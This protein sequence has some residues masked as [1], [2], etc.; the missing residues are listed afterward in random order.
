MSKKRLL[1]VGESSYLATGFS[2]YYNEV[3][4]RLHNMGEFEIAELGSYGHD[5]DPRNDLI[6]WKFYPAMPAP[7]DQ[8]GNAEYNSDVYNQFGKWRF[9]KVCLDFNPDIVIDIRDPWMYSWILRS[10]YRKHFNLFH[11]ACCDGI[12]QKPIWIEEYKQCDK[13]FTYSEWAKDI[14][15]KDGCNVADVMSPCADIDVFAPVVDKKAHKQS[16]GIDPE[17]YIIGT[18]MRNQKRKLFYDLI[19][20]YAKWFK[21][22]KIG[23]YEN[24][25]QKTYLYLHTSYPDVGFDIGRAIS[26]FGVS[27]R[28][29]MTYFCTACGAIY[30]SFFSG[31][32]AVCK[33]RK[34]GK[35]SAHPPN[36]NHHISREALANVYNLFDIYVQYSICFHPNTPILTEDG[37]RPIKEIKVKD[38]VFGRDGELHNVY[39]TMKNKSHGCREISVVGRPWKTIA[40]DN[41]PYLT[42]KNRKGLE[43]IK[44]LK[45]IEMEY[46]RADQ[47]EKDD[48]LVQTIPQEEINPI[49][50][51]QILD[52]DMAYYIGLFIGDGHANKKKLPD[53]SI[54]WPKNLQKRL[55]QGLLDSDGHQHGWLNTFVTIYESIARDLCTI[56]DRLQLSYNVCV[57]HKKCNDN[58]NRKLQYRF[59][60]RT[61]EKRSSA[62][63]LYRDGCVILKIKSNE[64]SSYVG[65]V[66]NIDVEDDHNY[67]TPAG[68]VHNCEGFG[69]P[70]LEAASCGLPRMAVNYSAM[71]DHNKMPASFHINV[72]RFFY[73]S[74]QET[75]QKR[76]LPDNDHFGDQLTRFFK[77]SQ[78]KRKDL[79]QK[80]RNYIVEPI[81]TI[82]CDKKISRFS[83][84]RVTAK[85]AHYFRNHPTKNIYQTWK[86]P[87]P[88]LFNPVRKASIGHLN[89]TEFVHW[90]IKNILGD[91]SLLNTNWCKEWVAALNSGFK[92]EGFR[93]VNIDR[94]YVVNLFM[95]IRQSINNAEHIRVNSLNGNNRNN[96]MVG[97]L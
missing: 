93:R 61:D 83:W 75:E 84:D 58:K 65:E 33:N 9:D 43:R 86:C 20:A 4:K 56:L 76:A 36:A 87:T 62:S 48:L 69:M 34:C 11:M 95:S 45:N 24:I 64:K 37:W 67:I 23:G 49:H 26:E 5:A 7:D 51:L 42:I 44:D 60:I 46:K 21:K 28:V 3:L 50:D 39:K 10:P 63:T 94:N 40:T 68:T 14:L 12:P 38:R 81:D 80:I 53:G 91:E 2:T 41:H 13:L 35:M 25:A 57:D 78:E 92:F 54:F 59:E 97:V 29:L 27:T 8:A 52:E 96:I 6:P 82:G 19:E 74:V 85:W 17:C 71:E 22:A 89:N 47:L 18:C 55:L 66:Y 88:I 31:Q 32:W 73:E 79:S 1:F 15:T 77:Q 72:G 70:L 16:M 90:T 30:P